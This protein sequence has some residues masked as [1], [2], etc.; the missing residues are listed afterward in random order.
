MLKGLFLYM[1]APVLCLI[2]LWNPA[3]NAV[4]EN[5]GAA[6]WILLAAL[7]TVGIN[8]LIYRTVHRRLPSLLVFAHGVFC[9][10]LT[11][12][13]EAEALPGYNPMVSTLSVIGGC[14][15]LTMLFLLSFWFAPR[16]SRID[17]IVAVGLRLIIGAVA[18]LMAAQAVRDIEIGRVTRDTWISIVILIALIPAACIR[19]ITRSA[20][21]TAFRRKATSLASGKIVQL[22][23][24]T[25]L[26]LDGD[27]VTEYIARIRYEA[28]EKEY[29][30]R[31]GI[32]G[33]TMRWFG[34]DSIVGLAIPVYYDPEKPEE[35]YANRIDRRMLKKALEAKKGP[36]EAPVDS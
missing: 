8:W 6:Y 33:I 17:H 23:G 11:V 12:I 14:L 27:P 31:S 19:R 2:C 21:K 36:G 5:N 3:G 13:M 28:G 22:I 24:E 34:K 26:D 30:T 16:K 9:L 10:L 18:F 7:G 1:L 4:R 25:R 32:N 15:A 35:A 20:R 29:E